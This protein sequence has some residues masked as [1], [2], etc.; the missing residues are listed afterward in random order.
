MYLP[1]NEGDEMSATV[2]SPSFVNFLGNSQQFP[3]A[4]LLKGKNYLWKNL[5]G[6]IGFT[7]SP[8]HRR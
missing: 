2:N 7:P 3:V 5:E 4:C 1:G 6:N 8:L